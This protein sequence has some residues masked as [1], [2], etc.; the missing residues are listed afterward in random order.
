MNITAENYGR[1]V[2][3]NIDGELTEDTVD[4]LRQAVDHQLET[5]DIVD[6]VLNMAKAPFIDSTVFEYLLDL[7]DK[8]IERLGQVKS[9][10]CDENVTMILEMTR[11]K[12]DFELFSD[13]AEA[14]KTVAP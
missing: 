12:N 3:L 5:Q 8:L 11:L 2:L 1:T 13:V 14:I 10:N 4:A 9:A 6:V 7:Q